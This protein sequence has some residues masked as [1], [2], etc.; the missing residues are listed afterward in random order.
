MVDA[1]SKLKRVN[2]G[3]MLDNA[4]GGVRFKC[5]GCGMSHHLYTQEVPP[6]VVGPRWTWNM[7]VE[8]PTLTPSIL[9]RGAFRSDVEDE[10]ND[11]DG[12][13]ICHSFVTDGR[14]QFLNDCTHALAG[15]TVDLPDLGVEGKG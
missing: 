8:R 7:D 15:Q 9:A 14:I 3:A 4:P 11:W 1:M 5:P 12:A 13:A 6:T 2:L 10:D